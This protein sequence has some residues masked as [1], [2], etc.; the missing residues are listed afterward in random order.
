VIL[1]LLDNAEL[2]RRLGERF[3]AGFDYLRQD[4]LKVADGRYEI[5]GD[6]VFAL[7]QSYDTKPLAQ[8]KWEAHRQYADIQYMISGRERMGVA[9]IARMK[10]QT[11]YNPDTDL[12]FFTGDGQMVTVEQGGF[13]IFLP[14][15]VHM[16][17]IAVDRVEPVKKV[18][19][20]VRVG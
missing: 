6:D 19:V 16:P 17:T 2:Y 3:V 13:T 10:T 7:V 4:L 15:D 12:E 11:P 8:G 18:V 20:K 5:V 1:D 14:H 9:P